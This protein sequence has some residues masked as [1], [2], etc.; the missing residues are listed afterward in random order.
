MG[1]KRT[2]LVQVNTEIL[3]SYKSGGG[4]GGPREKLI[5]LWRLGNAALVPRDVA[6]GLLAAHR[7]V[8]AA[9]GDFRVTDLRREVETQAKARKKYE[10]WL[11]A[12]KP[13]TRSSA[14]DRSTMKN[15]FVSRPGYSFHNAGRAMDVH[16][17]EL[18][19]PG[20]SEDKQLDKLWELVIP[21]GWRPIIQAA[22]ERESEAWHFDF[23]GEWEPVYDRLG[24]KDGAMCTALD[25]GIDCYARWQWRFIQ[26]QLQRAGYDLGEVDGYAGRKTKAALA[27]AGI[28]WSG[29]PAN[30]RKHVAA[31]PSSTSLVWGA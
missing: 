4:T 17:S 31:L 9:G 8:Q 6:D 18:D 16:I 19:F 29:S 7:A 12:G 25:I 24:Y 27:A 11:A 13:S 20:L 2:E 14:W 15:A 1:W 23:M 26:A 10:N 22:D 30:L 28:Q 3:S 21:L 5:P